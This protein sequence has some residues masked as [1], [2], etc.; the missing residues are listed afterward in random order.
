MAGTIPARAKLGQIRQAPSPKLMS[1]QA[2]LCYG[3]LL[4]DPLSQT[5]IFFALSL[6]A[7]VSLLFLSLACRR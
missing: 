6:S 4:F 1:S 5:P 2:R 3:L 7:L